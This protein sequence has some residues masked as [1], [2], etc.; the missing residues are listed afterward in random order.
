MRSI[1]YF[2]KIRKRGP[3]GIPYTW[4]MVRE[5]HVD[6]DNWRRLKRRPFS[7]GEM[8]MGKLA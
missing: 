4:V 5:A 1:R 7:L 6:E 8:M 2:Q 3:F